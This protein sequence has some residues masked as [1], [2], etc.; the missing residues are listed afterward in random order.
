M[1]TIGSCKRAASILGAVA[2]V[3]GI[4][5]YAS[6]PAPNGV[7]TVCLS[8]S[9]ALRAID[10]ALTNCKSTEQQIS[11]NQVG[12]QGP[13]GPQGPAG[14]Q[15][16]QGVP[17]PIGPQGPQGPAGAQG[18]PGVSQATV[19]YSPQVD[20]NVDGTYVAVLQTVLPSGSWAIQANAI[21]HDSFSGSQTVASDCELRGNGNTIAHGI[22]KRSSDGE[23]WATLPMNGAVFVSSGTAGVA[24]VWCRASQLSGFQTVKGTA[25]IMATQV[26]SFF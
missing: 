5:I 19:A 24:A 18:T 17:G 13:I 4:A 3:S 1:I 15:G 22:D 8:Q 14:P 21:I 11:W 16:P 20:L 9:G 6:I 23:Y 26:G 25:Q 2:L 12:P 10:T 7:I